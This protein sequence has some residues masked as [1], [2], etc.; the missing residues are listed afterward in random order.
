M[1]SVLRYVWAYQPCSHLAMK[2]KLNLLCPGR[3]V[4]I[5]S[6]FGPAY[7]VF[8]SSIRRWRP[9][10]YTNYDCCVLPLCP[11]VTKIMHSHNKLAAV[12]DSCDH[13]FWN[14]CFKAATRGSPTRSVVLVP[15]PR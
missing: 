8:A 14:C 13:V 5:A 2:F 9:V 1:H 6:L 10:I 3:R 12:V 4:I 7:N 15:E 11:L